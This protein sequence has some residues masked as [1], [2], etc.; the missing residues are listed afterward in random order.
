MA[1]LPAWAKTATFD[2]EARAQ[3]NPTKDEYREMVRTLLAERFK[4]QAHMES[5]QTKFY[6]AVLVKPGQPA[7][8]A[9]ASCERCMLGRA[10]DFRD[11]YGLRRRRRAWREPG[12]AR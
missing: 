10:D 7:A 12:E 11:G 5:K 6:A 9:S 2:I 3:G 8:A 4:L 1:Q